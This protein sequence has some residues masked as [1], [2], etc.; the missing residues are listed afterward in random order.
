[1]RDLLHNTFTHCMC[2]YLQ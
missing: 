2:A 1:M